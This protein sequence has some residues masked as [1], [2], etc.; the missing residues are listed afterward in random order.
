LDV[1]TALATLGNLRAVL[2]TGKGGVGKTSV[3]AAI[4]RMFAKEGRRV[5]VGETA[6]DDQAASPLAAALGVSPPLGEEPSAATDAID[7]VVL[8]PTRGHRAFLR[9]ALKVNILADAALRSAAIRRFFM[10]APTFP[11]MGM[12]YRVLELV[13]MKM[14]DGRPRYDSVILDLP[15]TGHALA[16]AQ[17]P[18]SLL[19]IL[20]GGPIVEAVK[21]GLQLLTDPAQTGSV[22]VTLPETLPVSEAMEL[23]DGIRKHQIPLAAMIANRVPYDPFTA[24]EKQ[25]VFERVKGVGPTLGVRSLERIERSRQALGRLGS[26]RGSVPLFI[27][28]ESWAEGAALPIELASIL[29]GGTPW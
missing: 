11:E 7:L 29:A 22:V 24:E 23:A 19:R 4:A 5:L 26:G 9:D 17:I 10:A 3:T 27:V 18:S 2:V 28:H 15:A 8:H 6:V 14:H 16:L 13:R 20:P 25:S 21:E 1:T 12:L